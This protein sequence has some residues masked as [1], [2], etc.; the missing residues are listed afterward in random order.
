MD[1]TNRTVAGLDVHK[2]S[3]FLCI[4]D[5]SGIKFESK[6]EMIKGS[7]IPESLIQDLRKYNRRIFDLNEELVY[8]KTKLD[9]ALQRCG[10]RLSNYVSDIGGKSYRKVAQAIASGVTDPQKLISHVHART[11]NKHGS[12]V[13]LGALTSTFSYVD[14]ACIRQYLEEIALAE[15]HR[16]ECQEKL[17]ALCQQ[18]FPHRLAQLQTIPGVKERTATSIIAEVGVDMK[19]FYTAAA[20]IGWCGLKPRND[21]SN[22]KIKSRKITH[23]NKFLRKTLIEAAWAASRTRG[24]FFSHFSYTQTVIRKK[25]K[26]KIIVAIARK[27]LVAVWHMFTKDEDFIDIYKM[28][29]AKYKIESTVA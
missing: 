21:E 18:Y 5:S 27:I 7:Y 1:S 23:G 24:C 14:I 15:Q 9:T 26:M 4:M 10:M 19:M 13:I 11:L 8:K 3:V 22:R 12:E 28:S 2:D 6:Y 17:T 20:L 25:N 29:V 16:N